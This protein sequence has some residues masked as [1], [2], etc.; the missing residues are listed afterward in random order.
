MII[1]ISILVKFLLIVFL[2]MQTH[3]HVLKARVLISIEFCVISKEVIA[4]LCRASGEARRWSGEGDGS[5]GK[6][7]PEPSLGFL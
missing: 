7:R 5:E 2:S 1:S 4:V 3:K 6:A